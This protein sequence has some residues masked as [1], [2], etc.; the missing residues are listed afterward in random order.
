MIHYFIDIPDE[1]IF[2]FYAYAIAI[3]GQ[4]SKDSLVEHLSNI[5]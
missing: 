2:I 3:I 5:Y 4:V 1:H